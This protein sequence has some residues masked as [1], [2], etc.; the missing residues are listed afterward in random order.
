M[1]DES[2][3]IGSNQRSGDESRPAQR[4]D[5]LDFIFAAEGRAIDRKY[6]VSLIRPS[7]GKDDHLRAMKSNF[8]S[9]TPLCRNSA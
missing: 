9:S 7:D 5:D 6:C 4:F 1:T 2:L 8:P 3:T